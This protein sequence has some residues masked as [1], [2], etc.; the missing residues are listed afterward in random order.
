MIVAG[1]GVPFRFHQERHEYS[2]VSTG[3]VVPHITGMLERAGLVDDTWYTEDSRIRGSAVHELTAAYDLDALDLATCDSPYKA[4]VCA[5]AEAMKILQAEILAI[6]QAFLHAIYRYGGRPDRLVIIQ[7]RKGVLEIKTG[8]PEK[9]VHP[10]QTALQAILVEEELQLPA[11][12]IE[13]LCLYVKPNGRYSLEEHASKRD[14][15]TA[16]RIIRE[17]TGR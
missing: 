16:R 13:R 1:A 9:K 11:D 5:Y 14:L 6:E 8:A 4:Y 2:I 17:Q 7:G 10:I 12:M 3:E 15:D